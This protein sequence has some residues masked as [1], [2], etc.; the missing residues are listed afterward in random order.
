MT[1]GSDDEAAAIVRN[2][3][4]GWTPNDETLRIDRFDVGKGE[5]VFLRGPS[6]SGKSTLLGLICG[7]L[8]PRSGTVRVAG[9]ELSQLSSARRDAVRATHLGVIFQMFN[10]VPFL[11]VL[12]NVTL[13]CRFSKE[14]RQRAEQDHRLCH[15]RSAPIAGTISA[16]P[17]PPSAPAP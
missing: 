1:A 5:K 9:E 16:L 4:Y 17:K 6:G 7:V 14:R 3:V 8:S 12:E 10:L 2:L 13:P 15:G 11:S